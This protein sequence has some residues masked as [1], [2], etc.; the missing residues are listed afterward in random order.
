MYVEGVCIGDCVFSS[1]RR[2]DGEDER[3]KAR[4][5]FGVGKQREDEYDELN[6]K[7]MGF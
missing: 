4:G 6:W 7:N 5:E 3:E 2:I 1:S